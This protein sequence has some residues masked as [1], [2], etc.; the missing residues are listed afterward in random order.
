[1]ER[2]IEKKEV[3]IFY[4]NSYV[5]YKL[6][7]KGKAVAISQMQNLNGS[8]DHDHFYVSDFTDDFERSANHFFGDNVR[9]E[10]YKLWE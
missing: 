6:K 7:E 8:D 5:F 9:L 10:Q 2:S 3:D 1:M 4:V